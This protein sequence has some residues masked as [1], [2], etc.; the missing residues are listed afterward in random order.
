MK[1][2]LLIIATALF[3]ACSGGNQTQNQS[4]TQS[5][6]KAS[7]TPEEINALIPELVKHIP[8][9]ELADDAAKYLT[10]EYY[11]LLKKA[12]NVPAPEDGIGDEEFL[13]YFIEGNGDCPASMTD[14][15]H[16]CKNFKTDI[17]GE[18]AVSTFDYSHGV[19]SESKKEQIDKHTI[20]LKKSANGWLIDNWDNTKQQVKDFVAKNTK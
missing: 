5:A 6:A 4:A 8:D 12:W 10:P 17:N 1:R 19:D 18:T 20:T 14:G 9:H 13:F 3:A 2:T 16:V 15:K 11:D 7:A